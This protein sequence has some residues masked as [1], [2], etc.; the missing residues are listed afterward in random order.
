MSEGS[1]TVLIG[2]GMVAQTHAD[3][4]LATAG[5]VRLV[6]VLA[7]STTKTFAEK[8]R[9]RAFG[10]IDEAIAS[11]PDFAIIATPPNAR[12]D[13]VRKLAAA[14]IPVLLEKP[15]ERSLT[16]A[17][18]VVETCSNAD[19][20]L[21][22]VFQHRTRSAVSTLRARLSEIGTIAAVE[23]SVPWW[24]EQ[25]YYDRPGRGTLAQDGG[26]VL[27][28]QAIHTLDLALLLAGPITHVQ[29]LSGTTSLHRMEAEDFV[30]AGLRFSNGAIGSLFATTAAYP[31]GTESITL[32]GKD[33]VAVLAGATLILDFYDGRT[34]RIGT[35]ASTGGGADP[36]GF[37]H[38]WHQAIIDDFADSIEQNREP[39]VT[40]QDALKVHALIDALMRSS[41]QKREV[42]VADV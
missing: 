30:T 5:K 22:V 2:T 15:I 7:R 20:P 36:M 1:K 33:G 14:D 24:R 10:S 29:A 4:I 32:R 12:L 21:G 19:I 6:G 42:E 27:I 9:C 13:L 37:T 3:A 17:R 40:G 18:K 35:A 38:K 34:E 41:D 25:S 11:N 23:I 8:N 16:T 39:L 31:G 26:G 28:T